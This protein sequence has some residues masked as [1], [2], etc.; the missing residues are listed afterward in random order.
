MTISRHVSCCDYATQSKVDEWADGRYREHSVQRAKFAAVLKSSSD[1]SFLHF[2]SERLSTTSACICPL[3]RNQHS[4]NTC[5]A[6]G[7]DNAAKER[8]QSHSAH[9]AAA[10]RGDL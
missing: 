10:P 3:I 4:S 5:R 8:A 6:Q 9:I 1:P 2:V 7:A